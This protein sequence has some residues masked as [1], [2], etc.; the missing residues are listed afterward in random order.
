MQQKGMPQD[1]LGSLGEDVAITP[2]AKTRYE[3]A[4]QKAK[5][6]AESAIAVRRLVEQP[7]LARNE[8][9]QMRKAAALYTWEARTQ[10]LIGFIEQ[11]RGTLRRQSMEA[12][13]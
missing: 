9:A 1:M 12:D 7:D 6:K 3:Q 11:V 4:V 2:E 13:K 8:G 5:A 10:S